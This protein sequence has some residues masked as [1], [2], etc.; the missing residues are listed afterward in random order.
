MIGMSVLFA[1]NLNA[2][3]KPGTFSV[4]PDIGYYLYT[5]DDNTLTYGARFGYNF[6]KEFGIEGS[7]HRLS[8]EEI[9]NADVDGYFANLDALF[10][11]YPEKKFTPYFTFGVGRLQ[12]DRSGKYK[13]DFTINFG[14]GIKYFFND[15]I[16]FRA[17]VSNIIPDKGTDLLATAGLSF[18]FGGEKEVQAVE[19][20]PA[21]PIARP[22]DSDGDGVYD[23]QDQCPN[24]P[25]GIRVDSRGCPVDSDGDGIYDDQ[26]QCPNTLAGITVDSRGCPMD[27]DGD[28]VLDNEDRCPATPKGATVDSRGCWVLRDL[29]FETNKADINTEGARIL[30]NVVTIMRSNPTLRLEIQGHTDNKGSAA[31]N[32][33]LSQKRAESVM[34]YLIGRGISNDR[35]SAM[36]YGFEKPA[37]SNDTVEGRAENRRVQLN[38][39]Q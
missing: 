21:P 10:Y 39:I 32:K 11:A 9:G 28:G 2:Q 27:S 12:L 22:E 3:V 19:E 13:S 36:G 8:T 5:K 24:T 31:Y 34:D 35:L 29:R 30:D 4:S 15:N 20:K 18:N 17:D 6:A 7:F 14:L 37:A 26:D 23:D 33:S 1:A 38:P 16:A 25:A